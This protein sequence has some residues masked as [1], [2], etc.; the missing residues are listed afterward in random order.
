M[1]RSERFV[2]DGQKRLRKSSEFRTA[3]GE[4][5]QTIRQENA[6]ELER[7]GLMGRPMLRARMHRQIQARIKRLAPKDA[8]YLSDG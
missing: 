1:N 5:V 4:I 7:A 3:C 8:H 6:D 2:A